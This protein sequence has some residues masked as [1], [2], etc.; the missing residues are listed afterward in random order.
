MTQHVNG[1]NAT[2]AGVDDDGWKESAG[3]P[4]RIENHVKVYLHL[5][6]TSV[7]GQ[8]AA[9]WAVSGVT[10]DGYPLD[11]T[12]NG[13]YC[14]YE[15]P[16]DRRPPRLGPAAPGGR[17]PGPPHRRRAAASARRRLGHQH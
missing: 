7:D 13:N 11:G 6:E 15:G 10:V 17:G 8:A 2:P 1:A 16:P 9:R 3:Y 5:E 14:D 4:H 12:E